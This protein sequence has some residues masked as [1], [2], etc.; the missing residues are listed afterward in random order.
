[1]PIRIKYV[2]QEKDGSLIAFGTKYRSPNAACR[3][4]G[5]PLN[6]YTY[7]FVTMK[8]P[9][10]QSLTKRQRNY[11]G[12]R[13]VSSLDRNPREK[14]ITTYLYFFQLYSVKCGFSCLAIGYVDGKYDGLS[15]LASSKYIKLQLF[16]MPLLAIDSLE[17]EQ[18]C[19]H[20][21][22]QLKFHPP[23]DFSRGK[24][25]E[26]FIDTPLNRIKLMKFITD[27]YGQR[28][29]L[30]ES[31]VPTKSNFH[32]GDFSMS[33]I[34]SHTEHRLSPLMPS[35]A[36]K[37][38]GGLMLWYSQ[39]GCNF[40]NISIE[41][42][43]LRHAKKPWK[44]IYG[45]GEKINTLLDSRDVC[46]TDEAIIDLIALLGH[47]LWIE[48]GLSLMLKADVTVEDVGI[49]SYV[50]HSPTPDN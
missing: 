44:L 4:H 29:R 37:I 50:H 41:R 20:K 36:R 6:T 49:Y 11:S 31:I 18:A 27:S 39:A 45:A 13:T 38:D 25:N 33:E 3:A 42:I 48:S 8:W 40:V 1:M 34:E 32:P 2:G 43:T 5:I 22:P 24:K 17:I 35:V 14:L 10:D 9:I 15:R 12:P 26:L 47:G 28:S 7:R 46:P 19:L 30:R 16:E 21:F 23:S